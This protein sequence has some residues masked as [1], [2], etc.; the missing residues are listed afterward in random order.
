LFYSASLNRDT[1]PVIRTGGAFVC[2]CQRKAPATG[3]TLSLGNFQVMKREDRSEAF[4]EIILKTRNRKESET[5]RVSRVA[6]HPAR[7]RA[8]RD[9]PL[10]GTVSQTSA[11]EL[12]AGQGPAALE[13]R[14]QPA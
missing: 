8:V 10:S 13:W 6:G 2:R 9:P 7:C 14:S 4:S 1:L 11:F 3:R 5:F 12:S